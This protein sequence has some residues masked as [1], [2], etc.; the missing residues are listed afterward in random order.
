MNTL[1]SKLEKY[2]PWDGKSLPTG[3]ARDLYLNKF[4]KYCGNKLVKV[5]V[6]QRRVGKS[7]LMRQL[8]QYLLTEHSVNPKNIFYLNKEY[9]VFDSV[10]DV[11]DLEELFVQYKN[12]LQPVGKIYIFI[13]EIQNILGWEK[14]VNSYSQDFTSE[15]ELFITGS[16]SNMLSGELASLLSGRYVEFEVYPF[17]F[18]EYCHFTQQS[19]SKTS[20]MQYLSMGGMPETYHFAEEEII[21]NYVE[22]LKNTIV[23]RDIISRNAIKDAQLL[24]DLFKYLMSNTGNFTS[25]SNIIKYF[26]SRSKQTNYETLSSY[27][28]YLC[29]SFIVHEAE[30]YNIRGKQLLGGDRKYYLNDLAFK[31]YLMGFYPTD[32]GAYLENY[33]YLRLKRLGYKLTVGVIN[34]VEI[35]FVAEND[36]TT[37]YFQVAYLLNSDATIEREFGNLQLIPDHFPKTVIS[38]DDVRFNDKNGIMHKR[39]WEIV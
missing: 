31:T 22:S 38:L 29:Q 36:G 10:R 8:I 28:S 33:V 18:G 30:R 12:T 24:E 32:T 1:V 23:L 4:K 13:D 37:Q 27:L 15:Y 19:E 7:Y 26:K 14:F 5:F 11:S 35:D 16:N 39:P 6:G 20:F 34:G 25:V 9:F 3:F 17:D 21:R 2:N